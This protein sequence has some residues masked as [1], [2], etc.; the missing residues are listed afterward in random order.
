MKEVGNTQ[1]VYCH[2]H[3]TPNTCWCERTKLCYTQQQVGLT[4][5]PQRSHTRVM[6]D[7]CLLVGYGM[8]CKTILVPV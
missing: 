7:V 1:A 4:K 8:D 2:S 3:T 6:Q 5:H